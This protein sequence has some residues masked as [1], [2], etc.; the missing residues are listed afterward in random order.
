MTYERIREIFN[1]CS[2]NQMR[3]VFFDEITVPTPEEAVRPYLTG[4]DVSCTRED[5]PGGSVIFDI[6]A[7][8]LRQRITLTPVD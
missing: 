2:N 4:K 5:T 6:E 7:N 8:G 1:S 3:D